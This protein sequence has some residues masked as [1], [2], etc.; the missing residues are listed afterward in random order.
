MNDAFSKT[1]ADDIMSVIKRLR[2]IHSDRLDEINALVAENTPDNHHVVKVFTD[3]LYIRVI[4]TRVA[5]IR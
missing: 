2:H 4:A 3:T 5:L 1:L